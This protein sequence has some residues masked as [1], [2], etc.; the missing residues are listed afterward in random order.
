MNNLKF[1][2]Q[3]LFAPVE[4]GQLEGWQIEKVDDYFIYVHPDCQF[5][6]SSG[7]YD[8][9]LI[10]YILNPHAP[11]ET[12]KQILDNLSR[13]KDMNDF[14]EKLYSLTGRFVLIIKTEDDFI[15]FNDACGFRTVYY[16]KEE[17]SFYAASQPLLINEVI[18]LK[19]TKAHEEYFNSEYVANDMEYY[20]PSGIT[21]Y[22]N[23][24]HLVP[25]HYLEVSASEQ[26]RYY[27]FRELKRRDYAEGVIAFSALLKNTILVAHN[28]LDLSFGLTAGWDT[29]IILSGCK[30]IASDVSF[31]TLI[32]RNMDDKHM[33]IKI[34]RSLSRLLHLNHKFLDC[35]KDITPEFA[36]IYK[37]N[38]DMAHINDWGKIAYGMSKTFPQEKVAVKGSCSE[39]GRCSWY[40]DGKHKVRLTDEDL[41]LLENGWEDI[42]FIREAIRKWYELIKKNSFNYPLLDLYYWEHAMGSW[43]AQSQLEWDIV[44][45]VFSPFNS[46]EMFDI[47]FSIDPLKRK[48]ENPAL[49][50][51]AAKYLWPEILSKPVNPYTFKRRVRLF[52]RGVMSSTGLL[53]IYQA[54]KKRKIMNKKRHRNKRL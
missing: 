30:D 33:D 4:C 24:Y 36:E 54:A 7:F 47:M 2:R 21:L 37:A 11:G 5:E 31:Y 41:L 19:K 42:A 9:Y 15:F 10:G 40:P 20:L 17:D 43:Q 14:P 39:V 22:E 26:K 46:R 51:D 44:Q 27:P 53:N 28:N 23:V 52:V 38:S 45:E 12:S 35:E 3:F 50:V 1:R 32:Y 25:N 34:P 18:P 48:Y 49:Y 16:T 13:V 6:K 8:L 29:R